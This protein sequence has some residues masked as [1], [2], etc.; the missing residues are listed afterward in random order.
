MTEDQVNVIVIAFGS[1]QLTIL[2]VGGGGEGDYQ[3]SGSG[4]LQYQ[5]TRLSSG[6]TSVNAIAGS[7][8]QPSSV[9]FNGTSIVANPGQGGNNNDDGGAGYSGGGGE[10]HR[11]GSDGSDGVGTNGGS[12]THEDISEYVFT[13]WTLTPG[14]GGY[15]IGTSFTLM[16]YCQQPI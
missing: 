10:G 7:H 14:N 13:T 1:C 5:K 3:G 15:P 12:G 9:S 11:G 8:A 6:I 4:F 16:H 2:A